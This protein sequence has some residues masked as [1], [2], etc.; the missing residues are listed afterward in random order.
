MTIFQQSISFYRTD[1][2]AT[3]LSEQFSKS[4]GYFTDLK[5]PC[6]NHNKYTQNGLF[7]KNLNKS[8]KF[9]QDKSYPKK[10]PGGDHGMGQQ[11]FT[12]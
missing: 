10:K 12:R 2:L 11:L 7:I 6:L 8:T 1:Y 4:L 3:I 5:K 9:N